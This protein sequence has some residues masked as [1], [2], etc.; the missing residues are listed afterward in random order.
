M[1]RISRHICLLITML[2]GLTV[3][4]QDIQ[5]TQFYAAPLFLNPAFAGANVCSRFTTNYR[6]QWPGIKKTYV[7]YTASYDHALPKINS[8][9]GFLL[10]NDKAGTGNLRTTSISGLFSYEALLSRKWALRGG[11]QA[12][13]TFRSIDFRSLTFGDQIARNNA[14]TVEIPADPSTLY[15][16]VGAGLLAYTTKYWIGLA[17]HHLTQPNQSLIGGES[18]LPVKYSFH[19]GINLPVGSPAGMKKAKKKVKAAKQFFSPAVNYRMQGKFRQLDIGFYYNYRPMVLGVWYRG[20]PILKTYNPQYINHD[21]IAFI[22]GFEAKSF[23][24]GYSYDLTVSKLASAAGGSHE[25]SMAYQFCDYASLKKRK[26]KFKQNFIIP[27]A[28]F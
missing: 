16:D 7:T 15:F 2:M 5:F 11:V 8:G 1:K 27:C 13:E 12:G 25:L 6:N 20:I 26:K 24:F 22:A 28:K 23:K 21:A 9:I 17:A 10:T 18:I 3:L 4:A 19:S 14:P